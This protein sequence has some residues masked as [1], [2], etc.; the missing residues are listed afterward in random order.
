MTL[1]DYNMVSSTPTLN[2]KLR[3]LIFYVFKL[4]CEIKYTYN[5]AHTKAC[6]TQQ[7]ITK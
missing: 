5:K 4:H 2:G 6:T 7:G 1:E 3:N